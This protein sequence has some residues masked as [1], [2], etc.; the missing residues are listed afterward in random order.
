MLYL[1][2]HMEESDVCATRTICMVVVGWGMGVHYRD[3]ML[4]DSY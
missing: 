1:C 3:T 4:V 2:A